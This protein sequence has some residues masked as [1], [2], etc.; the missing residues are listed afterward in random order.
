[1]SHSLRLNIL[2]SSCKLSMSAC[3][4]PIVIPIFDF[5]MGLLFVGVLIGLRVFVGTSCGGA[6]KLRTSTE[7]V[8]SV[9]LRFFCRVGAMFQSSVKVFE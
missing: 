9:D 5:R 6:G 4:C 2:L 7:L 1:M 8:D 3:F